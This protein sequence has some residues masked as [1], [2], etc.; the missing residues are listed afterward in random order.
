MNSMEYSRLFTPLDLGFTQLSN[1]FVMG[2][3][4]TGLED[5]LKHID[6]LTEYFAERARGGVG[7]IVTGGYSPN[8]LGKLSPFGSTFTSLKMVRAHQ[9]LTKAVHAHGSK[10]CLQLLHAGRY[11]YHPFSVAPSRIKSPITPFTP[12]AMAGWYVKKTIRD[13]AQA[14]IYA[15]QAGYD[16]VE[17]MGS[18]GYLIHQF[19]SARTNLR[20]DEWGGTFEKRSRF[21][22]E[23][24]RAVREALGPNSI[25]I[26]RLSV[27]DLVEG[28]ATREE[29]FSLA[30]E[31]EKAGATLLNSGIGWHEAR[32]PT[33]ASMVP[34]AAFTSITAELRQHVKIPVVATNRINDPETAEKILADGQADLISMARP[35]LA[36]PHFVNKAK[37]NQAMR[38]NPCI[39]C[40]QACL[41]NIFQ[42]KLASCMVNPT[43]CLEDEWKITFS[44]RSSAPKNIAVV[45]AGPAG[46]NAA[47]VLL[48]MGHE[49]TVHE[50]A[51]TLG[52]QFMLAALIPGKKDYARSIEHW[53]SEIVRLGG[54]VLLNSE[55]NPDSDT[56]RKY[57]HVVVATGVL[58]RQP[59][60]PGDHLPHVFMYDRFLREGIAPAN[61]VAIIGAGGIGID[62]ATAIYQ[63]GSDTD[64]N[65]KNFFAHWGINPAEKSG[66]IAGFKHKKSGR[67]VTLLQ[68][69]KAPMGSTLGKTTGWI[70][71]QELK[72]QG[73]TYLNDLTYEEITS[74]G[75][76]IKPTQGE[77][78][79]ITAQQVIICAGQL[80]ENSLVE[81][82]K[83]AGIQHSLIGGARLAGEL[84]AV[85]AIQDA[86][87]LAKSEF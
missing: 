10:I 50:K 62:V 46:L 28:G 5:N 67:T 87:E 66:L 11:S 79:F 75:V 7:L 2:S 55:L 1:R 27:L 77:R 45:G 42:N 23:I 29:V 51:G 56:A 80:S 44:K 82:L 40:N 26:F 84:D 4:H 81:K 38:I 69:K 85:R 49:V 41:D 35:F 20:S 68:R 17:I 32:I 83:R 14:A 73:V 34:H 76:W 16:G 54:K 19:L 37:N 70:H 15:S 64:E 86:F 53:H 71:R 24:V 6:R 31:I 36:D 52:G 48:R 3:I 58:P 43:A 65:S 12:F 18:E 25:I 57:D 78:R 61:T 8:L 74:E 30:R 47:L 21:A 39:A 13:F 33:I 63:F 60:I 72:H 59:K 22:L 9:T